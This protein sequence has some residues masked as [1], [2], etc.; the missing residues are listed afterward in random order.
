[1]TEQEGANWLVAP[2]RLEPISN[3]QQARLCTIRSWRFA[4]AADKK[5]GNV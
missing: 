2:R 3:K 4:G 5:V 1:M